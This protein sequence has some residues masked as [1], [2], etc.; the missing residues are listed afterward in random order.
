MLRAIGAHCFNLE[1]RTAVLVAGTTTQSIATQGAE[2]M[3][4]CEG[5]K[6]LATEIQQI[7]Q[8]VLGLPSK[9]S[10]VLADAELGTSSHKILCMKQLLRWFD[11]LR[12]DVPGIV[13]SITEYLES[14]TS[15]LNLG[16]KY[17]TRD[18]WKQLSRFA[19]KLDWNPDVF[20]VRKPPVTWLRPSSGFARLIKPSMPSLAPLLSGG[21]KDGR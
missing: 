15:T 9:A 16:V 3:L 14:D 7:K 13:S 2:V 1:T 20:L 17:D 4:L 6:V 11:T 5:T 8:K 21:E 18:G 12:G 19:K 10:Y